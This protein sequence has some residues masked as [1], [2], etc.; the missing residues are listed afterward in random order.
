MNVPVAWYSQPPHS[1]RGCHRHAV[2]GPDATGKR[3]A[4]RQGTGKT[5]GEQLNQPGR[6]DTALR[7]TPGDRTSRSAAGRIEEIK[8]GN[9]VVKRLLKR[10]AVLAVR[11]ASQ[12]VALL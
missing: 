11:G 10:P 5:I 2:P 4:H 1:R 8:Q 9:L 3:S 7:V 12:R 6:D